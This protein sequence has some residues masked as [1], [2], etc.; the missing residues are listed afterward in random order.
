MIPFANQT[1]V[2][3]P[4]FS[5]VRRGSFEDIAAITDHLKRPI[6]SHDIAPHTLEQLLAGLTPHALAVYDKNLTGREGIYEFEASKVDFQALL[7]QRLVPMYKAILINNNSSFAINTFILTRNHTP[8]PSEDMLK[9]GFQYPVVD[10]VI[11]LKVEL[12]PGTTLTWLRGELTHPDYRQILT[13]F[14]KLFRPLS[15]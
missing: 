14:K 12:E 13:G 10:K 3:Q 6:V 11:K 8:E 15:R 1:S 5:A 4:H 7:K 2:N 9:D